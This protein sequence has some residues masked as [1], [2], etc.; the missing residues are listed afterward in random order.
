MLD[1]SSVLVHTLIQHD[2]VD[3]YHLLVYPVALGG[4]K[5]L[6]P[7]GVRVNLRLIQATMFLPY[8]DGGVDRARSAG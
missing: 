4:G 8:A 3:E 7:A 5:Q 2:L 1:G 6:F